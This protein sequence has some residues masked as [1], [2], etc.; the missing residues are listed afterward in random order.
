MWGH[1]PEG[2]SPHPQLIHRQAGKRVSGRAYTVQELASLLPQ[3]IEIL[4]VNKGGITFS[5]GEPLIQ[6]DFVSKVIDLLPKVH[7][8]LDTSGFGQTLDFHKLVIR[9]DL[10]FFDLKSIEPRAHYYYTGLD[11]SIILKDLLLIEKMEKPYVIRVPLVPGVIDKDDNLEVIARNVQELAGLMRIDLFSNNLAAGKKYK[12][13]GM[14]F[15]PEYDE[16]Q[17]VNLKRTLFDRAGIR[18]TVA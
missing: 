16:T 8:C 5:G 14:A 7:I 3:P 6:T 4:I 15:Q 9:S 12:S 1:N 10:V 13:A 17:P 11:N 18:V 2:Q